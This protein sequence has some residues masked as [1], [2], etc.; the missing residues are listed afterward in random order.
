VKVL[1]ICSK[2]PVPQIDGGCKAMNNITQG[3]LKNNISVKVLTIGTTK[4]PF[5]LQKLD[6]DY[7]KN[8]NIESVFIDTEVKPK[9]AFLNLFTSDSYNINRFISNDF[10]QLIIRTLSEEEYDI[11]FLEG[12]YV[13]PYINT[14]KQESKA[15]IIYRSHN[16]EHEIWERNLTQENK[17]LKKAYLQLLVKRL[18]K[19][20]ISILNQVDGIAAI[21]RKDEKALIKLGAKCPITVTPFGFELNINLTT[22]KLNKI[23]SFFHIGSMDWK[24]NQDGIKWFLENI[25]DLVVE[26]HPTLKFK[27][28]GK[29]M[30]DWLINW[31]QKNVVISGEV[32]D[33]ISFIQ[34]NDVMIVPLFAGSGMRI[35]IIEGMA[36]AKPIIATSIAAEGIKYKDNTDII[37]ANKIEEYICAIDNIVNNVDF[38]NQIGVEAKKMIESNYNNQLIVNNLVTFFKALEK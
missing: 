14:I 24:P 15:K 28:A 11:I 32:K 19:Y 26:K 8:T 18:K 25:W 37:I 20:E 21:T 6:A 9:D 3:L 16:I 10:E 22:K 17:A 12:L 38:A 5:S 36:L 23:E 30:P 35:K 29:S 2:P 33:A 7:I 1:Q 34:D 4:H 31:K 13:T 27:I